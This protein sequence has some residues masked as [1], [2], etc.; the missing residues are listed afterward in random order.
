VPAYY[1]NVFLLW[2]LAGFIYVEVLDMA[3]QAKEEE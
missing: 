2:V 3:R 1:I